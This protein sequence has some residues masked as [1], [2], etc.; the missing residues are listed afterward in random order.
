MLNKK[1]RL[2]KE[3]FQ[4]VLKNGKTIPGRLFLFKFKASNLPQ[5]A[6]V[7]PKTLAK[8][9]HLRNKLRRQGYYSLTKQD[10]IP[11]VLGVFFYKKQDKIPIFKDIDEDIASIIRKLKN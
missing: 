2:T 6:F 11:N 1:R 9:A 3:L 5:Y 4:D 10:K 8:E 7:A